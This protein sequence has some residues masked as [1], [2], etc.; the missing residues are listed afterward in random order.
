MFIDIAVSDNC[1]SPDSYGEIC[2]QCNKRGT[3]GGGFGAQ[4]DK[5][6]RNQNG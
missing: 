5:K 1:K 4:V 2:A 3:N 6:R